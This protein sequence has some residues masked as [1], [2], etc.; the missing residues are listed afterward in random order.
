MRHWICPF[1]LHKCVYLFLSLAS[2]SAAPA[3]PA[4]TA[5][6]LSRLP[7]AL[8]H[9]AGQ[10]DPRVRFAS[11]TP[12]FTLLLTRDETIFSLHD[13]DR[14]AVATAS[15]RLA[16]AHYGSD[17]EALDRLPGMTNYLSGIDP[18]R[19]Q[20]GVAQYRRVRYRGVYPGVDVA[21][22]GSGRL[23]EYDFELHPGAEASAI[24]LA[25]DGVDSVR[26][27]SGGNLLLDI[28][29]RQVVQRKPVAYQEIAGR[30]VPVDAR[31]AVDRHTRQVRIRVGSYDHQRALVIDP[32]LDY[33]TF[34]GGTGLDGANSLAVDAAGN[35]Y[36]TGYTQSANLPAGGQRGFQPAERGPGDAFVAKLNPAGN[37]LVY[38]TYL[39][40]TGDD[41]GTSI[42]VDA[43]GNAYLCGF[44]NSSNFPTTPG[45]LAPQFSGGRSDGFLAVL[46]S[47]GAGLVFSTYLGGPGDDVAN[48][49]ALDT[50]GNIYVAGYSTSTT[51]AAITTQ[52]PQRTNAGA[53]DAFL[54]KFKSSGALVYGT[55]FGGTGN[56]HANAVA[57]DAGGSA[58]VVG[59]STSNDL[60]GLS[61]RSFQIIHRAAGADALLFQISPDGTTVAYSTFLGGR[62][63]QSAYGLAILGNF[64]YIT[65]RTNS[66]DFPV[67]GSPLQAKAGGN[68]DAFV[69]L[70]IGSPPVL[71][72]STYLGGSGN[73]AGYG[74]VVDRIG[75]AYVAGYT[76]SAN[77]LPNLANPPLPGANTFV[78]ELGSSAA[79]ES[80]FGSLTSR[81]VPVFAAY[82][83][84]S[85]FNNPV[86]LAVRASSSGD[87]VF[88]AGYG[89][90]RFTFPGSA[91]RP[92]FPYAG[93][94]SDAFVAKLANADVSIAF[95]PIG[96]YVG[97]ITPVFG[98]LIQGG[99]VLIPLIVANAGPR[100]ADNVTFTLQ[101][102]TGVTF[103]RCQTAGVTCSASA[104]VVSGTI[105]SLAVGANQTVSIVL[106]T[107]V[108]LPS[109]NL[110]LSASVLSAINDIKPENN[111]ATAAFALI[112]V[113]P[114]TVN[115]VRYDFGSVPVGQSMETTILI[116]PVPNVRAGDLRLDLQPNTAF[117]L[118][119]G[120]VTNPTLG[121]NP[122]TVT[123][124]FKPD[125]TGSQSVQLD[126]IA[127]GQGYTRTIDLVGQGTA[128][129]IPPPV[130]T[131]VV[132]GAG[133]RS[134]I[135]ANGWVT[136]KGTGF[137]DPNNPGRSWEGRD[138]QGNRLPSM[139]DGIAVN[140][141][142][143]PA[144]VSYIS[145]TQINVLAPRDPLLGPVR[146][147]LT[148]PT[149]TATFTAQK[150]AVA[151]GVFAVYTPARN[152]VAATGSAGPLGT[153][154][155]PAHPNQ[156]ISLYLSGLGD[157]TP[158]YSDG[159]PISGVVNTVATPALTIGGIAVTPSYSGMTPTAAGLYQ[160]NLT[161]PANTPVGDQ[162]VV[163]QLLNHS[164]QPAVYI[165]IAP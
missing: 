111:T 25:F 21:Y 80:I 120:T 106:K 162:V 31:Y 112:G 37:G 10:F 91:G 65:G 53:S 52:A 134:P 110:S 38:V 137:M 34:F 104:G 100:A 15:L 121:T 7:L 102:P 140:I 124:V 94:D 132:D 81:F 154:A 160:L 61:S 14:R 43:S 163:L 28:A 16:G 36:I 130:I 5:A 51:M 82:F 141:N 69:S 128:P 99:D 12:G 89:D 123:V 77:L 156:N 126:V 11:R 97:T 85:D 164:T 131:E 127:G 64:L 133:F 107:D 78:V 48:A 1:Q 54:V 109:Q 70:F 59:D 35:A 152:Y 142:Q 117:S 155:N 63:D 23:L 129:F 71:N 17:P 138:F 27:A 118:R 146:V 56:E 161:L 144:Y 122:L 24:R 159:T 30:R 90:S 76:A 19:W 8:E 119:L 22:Y 92:L 93:G 139:L 147:D 158:A 98:N 68:Y 46:N 41:Q 136:L 115:P 150:D 57:V 58:Y 47:T 50:Q 153:P 66:P 148:T 72:Y 40:G 9:N 3:Q 39:G 114:F 75:D 73:D 95:G 149:G 103:V 6:K 49:L 165:T 86:S 67:A 135:A 42:A 20:T 26:I 44:T 157:T 2:L 113:I 55:F 29:G 125:A 101:L 45:A 83:G 105:A 84:A 4:A 32:V 108:N 18:S 33:G 116:A 79:W 88:V 145:P 74:I 96:P 13:P 87:E 60:P 143:K 62:S 151:P